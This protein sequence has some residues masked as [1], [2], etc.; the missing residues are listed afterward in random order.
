MTYISQQAQ[1]R[2]KVPLFQV[3]FWTQC[4]ALP[5]LDHLSVKEKCICGEMLW[6]QTLLCSSNPLALFANFAG[7]Y[8]DASD[9]QPPV[10]N[11]AYRAFWRN[12]VSSWSAVWLCSRSL[13]TWADFLHLLKRIASALLANCI[14]LAFQIVSDMSGLATKSLAS[15]KGRESAPLPT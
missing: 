1:S 2:G 3:D 10:A 9:Q 14:S 7:C 8:L 13:L 12:R 15:S 5:A 6:S 11:S 4:F